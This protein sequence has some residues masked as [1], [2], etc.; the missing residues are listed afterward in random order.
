MLVLAVAL[1]PGAAHAVELVLSHMTYVGSD[2]GV[3]DV[4]LEAERAR[5]PSGG[6]VA[7]LEDVH[8]D[9]A[10]DGGTSSLVLTADRAELDLAT[11]D[12][13]ARGNVHGRTGDGHRFRTEHAVFEQ[14][15]Q[16]IHGDAPVDIIDPSGT[17]LRGRGFRY[18]VRAGRMV[19]RN[20]VVSD[21]PDD[22]EVLP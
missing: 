1:V 7:L 22:L 10:G 5:I 15:R 20:A 21:A 2:A 16:I 6:D 19:M 4:V 8:L 17:R 11:N 12:F 3:P 14:G 9:A 13:D 18:D